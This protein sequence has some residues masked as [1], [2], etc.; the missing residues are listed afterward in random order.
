MKSSLYTL[1][2]LFFVAP[3]FAQESDTQN[4]EIRI[5]RNHSTVGFTI[6]IVSGISMVTGKFTDFSVDLVW[7]DEDPS[8]SSVFLEIQVASI[9]TGLSGRDGDITGEGILDETGFPTITFQSTDIRRNGTDFIAIGDF[10]LHGVTKE[11]FLPVRVRTFI[12]ED[13]PDDPWRAYHISYQL[14]RRDY[15]INWVRGSLDFFVGY[16]IDIDIA[17]LER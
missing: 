7:D 14:D 13:N 15:G 12:D 9:T 6:P 11:I 3:V 2:I 10:T 8:K 16:D 5:D 4:E 17:L 1:L